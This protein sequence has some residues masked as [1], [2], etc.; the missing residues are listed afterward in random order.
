MVGTH[1][2]TLVEH[3]FVA[4]E[5]VGL[6]RVSLIRKPSLRFD[7]LMQRDV[8]GGSG[9]NYAG[10]TTGIAGALTAPAA[11]GPNP[12]SEVTT[13]SNPNSGSSGSYKPKTFRACP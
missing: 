6:V 5:G 4:P 11:R 12:R 10:R 1:D 8:L 13:Y 3:P 9:G 7:S 2:W